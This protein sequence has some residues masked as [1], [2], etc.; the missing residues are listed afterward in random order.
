MVSI[1]LL[2]TVATIIF[3]LWKKPWMSFIPQNFFNRSLELEM[4]MN[5]NKVNQ[6]PDDDQEFLEDRNYTQDLL[7]Y[8]SKDEKL[9]EEVESHYAT[10]QEKRKIKATLKNPK[11][12]MNNVHWKFDNEPLKAANK[13]NIPDT[14][15]QS[16][17]D[18][19]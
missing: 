13:P 17:N 4:D 9:Q 6:I 19:S 2:T 5:L 12:P 1:I 18:S 14:G 15:N 7:D 3:V 11:L 10:I 8:Q 16:K